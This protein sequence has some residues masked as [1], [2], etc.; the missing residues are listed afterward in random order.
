MTAVDGVGAVDV[1]VPAGL[2]PYQFGLV[3]AANVAVKGVTLSEQ[4]STGAVPGGAGF[5]LTRT[6]IEARSLSQPFAS[7]WVT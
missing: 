7:V 1:G 6:E 2:V 4:N 3:P 5:C